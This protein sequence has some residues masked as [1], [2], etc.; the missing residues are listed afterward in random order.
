LRDDGDGWLLTLRHL[1]TF[2]LRGSARWVAADAQRIVLED[3][4]PE[5]G[6]VLLSLHYEAGMHVTPSRVAVQRAQNKDDVDFVRL[7][8]ADPVVTR[9][10]ITWEKHGAEARATVPDQH[11][12]TAP[13]KR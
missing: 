9:I 5:N 2:A 8:I 3:V 1:P 13:A 6:Q 10:T 7:L 12:A 11:A 4:R